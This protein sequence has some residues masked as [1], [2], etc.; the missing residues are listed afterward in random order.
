MIRT[1]VFWYIFEFYSYENV[2]CRVPRNQNILVR[3]I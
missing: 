2:A 3:L 1:G